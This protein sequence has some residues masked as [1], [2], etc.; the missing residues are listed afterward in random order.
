MSGGTS[1]PGTCRIGLCA[2]YSRGFEIAQYMLSRDRSVA[3]VVTCPDDDT[4]YEER[5]ADICDKKR[6]RC[7]RRVSAND[8]E[9]VDELKRLKIDIVVLGW[10]PEI[11]KERA[12]RSVGFGWINLHPSLLPYGRGKH[13][14]Y[15]AVVEG[16]PFGVS[17]HLV[18]EGIDS[19]P[20]LVQRR[21]PVEFTD[22]GESLYRKS[23]DA[24]VQLFKESYDDIANFR[25]PP[26]QQASEE[27]TFH[28]GH[29]I[30]THSRI[31][32]DARYRAGD[33]IDI[34]RARTFLGGDSAYCFQ[35]GKRYR[36]KLIVEADRRDH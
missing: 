30:E 33:L 31:N 4:E 7:F 25:L 20:I 6:V 11:V 5:I 10:W 36:L 17:I 3:F 32:L 29:E 18:D 9:F 1:R 24:V 13:G 27:A 2:A 8:P 26:M 15:W 35:G 28:W 12:I 23:A 14:Y 16:T 34:L 22:T 21:L 19:G